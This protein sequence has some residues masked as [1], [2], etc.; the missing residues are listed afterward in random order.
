MKVAIFS[1]KPYDRDYFTVAN[2]R[3][4]FSLTFFEHRLDETTVQLAEGFDA[5][6]VFVN[7][8][9]NRAVLEQLKRLNV[10]YIA[11]RCAGYNN[12]D[13][14]VANDLEIPLVRVPSYSPNAVAEHVI[15]L[16]LTLYRS[17]H[18]AYNRVREGNFSLV[19]MT[20]HEVF[21]KTVGVVGTG[22]IGKVVC[23]IF[24][25]FGCRVLATDPVVDDYLQQQP[26]LEYVPIERLY[27]ESD[28]ISLHC[29][30]TEET[31]HMINAQ[32][33]AMMKPGVTLINTSRGGLVETQDAYQALK[34]KQLGF[35]AID[36]YEEEAN[37]FFEDLSTEIIMDDLFMRLTT[38][39][40]VLITGHQGFFTERALSNIAQTTL[41]NLYHLAKGEFCAN[42]IVIEQ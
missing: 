11:L 39:P 33:L 35:L 24:G 19:G 18:K 8:R 26:W 42:R 34:S 6:C 12:V 21:G 16:L 3:F 22:H 2:K 32:T 40:N 23:K 31:R 9:L 38:F 41:Q 36:V 10:R 1:S 5:V 29:P 7:D 25:G 37:L 14:P 20:G 13:L 4:N 17:T 27:A 28:I 30:L 15:A